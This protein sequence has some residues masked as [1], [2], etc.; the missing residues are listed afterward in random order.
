MDYDFVVVFGVCVALML[1]MSERYPAFCSAHPL[2]YF[3]IVLVLT[4]LFCLFVWPHMRMATSVVV[5]YI[6]K[7]RR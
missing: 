4:C 6:H 3:A 5:D 1:F 7:G 2:G